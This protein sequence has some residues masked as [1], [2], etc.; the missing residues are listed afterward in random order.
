MKTFPL[1]FE[2]QHLLDP[3]IVDGSGQTGQSAIHS[4]TKCT[5]TGQNTYQSDRKPFAANVTR[6][7]AFRS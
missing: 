1:G 3:V 5:W 2:P 7:A 4:Q 6:V